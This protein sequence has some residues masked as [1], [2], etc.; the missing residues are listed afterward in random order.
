MQELL[1]RKQCPDAV[2]TFNDYV[3]LDCIRYVKK[4]N[5][6]DILFVSFANEPICDYIDDAPIAS[7]EQ[8]PYLQGEK[9]TTM[10]LGLLH[11]KAGRE[12]D[13]AIHELLQSQLVIHRPA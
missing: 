4:A 5:I 12:D 7:V 9:A 10:L 6:R 13:P 3:A 8:F 11:K 1:G 2:I